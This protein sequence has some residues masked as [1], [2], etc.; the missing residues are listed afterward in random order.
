MS[1]RVRL[2]LPATSGAANVPE[3]QVGDYLARGWRKPAPAAPVAE[4]KPLPVKRNP[5]TKS[6]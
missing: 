4:P 2:I 1:G 3:S 5:R 6:D